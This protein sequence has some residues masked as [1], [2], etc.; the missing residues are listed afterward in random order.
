MEGR[1]VHRYKIGVIT[2]LYK[3]AQRADTEEDSTHAA[4]IGLMRVAFSSHSD[5]YCGLCCD[6][7]P[8][9]LSKILGPQMRSNF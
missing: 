4:W 8:S 5:T 9:L 1:V 6:D 3:T 2:H 7:C